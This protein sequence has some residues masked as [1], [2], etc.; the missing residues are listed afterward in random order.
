MLDSIYINTDQH[1]ANP[2]PGQYIVAPGVRVTFP[3]G[4]PLNQSMRE[5]GTRIIDVTEQQEDNDG[6]N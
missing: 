6:R 4:T 5:D 3:D 1:I 2:T